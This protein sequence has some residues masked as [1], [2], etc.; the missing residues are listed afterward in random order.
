VTEAVFDPAAIL[1]AL[2]RRGV[3]F[4]VIGGAAAVLHGAPYETVDLD[5]TPARDAVNLARL[6]EALADLDAEL[7]AEAPPGLS[8]DAV[9]LATLDNARF[10]TRG[11][12]LDLA[13]TPDGTAGFDDLATRSVPMTIAGRPMLVAALADVIRSKEAA[14]REKDLAALPL[15][16]RL[17]DEIDS[18]A[19][20]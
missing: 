3:R 5:V 6:V 14:G 11:G 9:L 16:R 19:S 1:L 18:A 13:F 17:L 7:L 4:V 20:E 10:V 2:E 12:P 15:L 8:V